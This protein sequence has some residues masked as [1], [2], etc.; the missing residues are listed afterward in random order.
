M[1]VCPYAYMFGIFYDHMLRCT[2]AFMLISSNMLGLSQVYMEDRI[3]PCSLLDAHLLNC[4]HAWDAH[5][6]ECSHAIML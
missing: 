1:L 6:L 5:M 3:L 4:S 2:Y